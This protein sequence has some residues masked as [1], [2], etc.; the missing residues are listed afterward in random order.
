MPFYQRYFLGGQ[1]FRG[2]DFRAVSPKGIRNDNGQPSTTSV[3]GNFMFF[4]GAEVRHQPAAGAVGGTGDG[5]GTAV[6][7]RASG[8]DRDTDA[9]DQ[10]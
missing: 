2:F 10:L 5:A 7:T 3:G 8:A 1:T 4:A 6:P 9:R